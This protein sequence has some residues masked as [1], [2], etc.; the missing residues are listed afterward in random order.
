MVPS[1]FDKLQF[2]YKNLTY[3]YLYAKKSDKTILILPGFSGTHV[4][5]EDLSAHLIDDYSVVLC[6]YPG[7]GGAPPLKLESHTIQEYCQFI[8]SLLQELKIKNLILVGHCMGALLAINLSQIK[9]IKI[10]H[11]FLLNPPYEKGSLIFEI[12][13][14]IGLFST[15]VKDP[16]KEPFFFWRNKFITFIMSLKVFNFDST[17]KRLRYAFRNA[18]L[19][20]ENETVARENA[21][22]FYTYNWSTISTI[23]L[24][25]HIFYSGEDFI[26]S[27]KDIE[28]LALLAPKQTT[29]DL[30]KS[31]GHLLPLESPIKTAKVIKSYLQK[32]H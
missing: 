1:G 20:K 8:E 2:V 13:K 10:S 24:P 18:F 11:V 21:I 23:E 9:N 22:S 4:D 7:W 14:Y 26:V 6:N 27:Q 25:L 19:N 16:F 32:S 30:F 15:R 5:F 12:L 31:N 17:K 29:Y 3:D 28:N